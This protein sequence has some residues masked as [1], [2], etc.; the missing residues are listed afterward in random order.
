MIIIFEKCDGY[1]RQRHPP[2][3]DAAIKISEVL[4]G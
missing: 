4:Q 2:F 3:E 1:K